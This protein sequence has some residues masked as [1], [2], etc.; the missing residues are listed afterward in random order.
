SN[1]TPAPIPTLDSSWIS[2]LNIRDR[3]RGCEHKH[4]NIKVLLVRGALAVK[5]S[6]IVCDGQTSMCLWK[7]KKQTE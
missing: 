7:D 5:E 1:A 6:H 2:F 4:L 3:Q